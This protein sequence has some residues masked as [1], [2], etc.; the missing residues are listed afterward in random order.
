MHYFGII[1]IPIYFVVAGAPT[2]TYGSTNFGPSAFAS[3]RGGSRV[4]AYKATA[5]QVEF[6]KLNSISAM[7]I[8]LNK[9]PEEIRSEDYQSGD[10]GSIHLCKWSNVSLLDF[11]GTI[12]H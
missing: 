4:E 2:P 10:K 7:P 11:L 12:M 1:C 9:S 8:Y 5:D 3:K 6:G